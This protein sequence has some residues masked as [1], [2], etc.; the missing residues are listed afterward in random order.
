MGPWIFSKHQRLL[1]ERPSAK[2]H[3][4]KWPPTKTM[5]PR[6]WDDLKFRKL[7]ATFVGPM[8]PFL[9]LCLGSNKNRVYIFRTHICVFKKYVGICWGLE[10]TRNNYTSRLGRVSN[11]LVTEHARNPTKFP[12]H[13]FAVE[14]R[15]R[16]SFFVNWIPKAHFYGKPKRCAL[17]MTDMF[18]FCVGAAW[19]HLVKQMSAPDLTNS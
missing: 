1:V 19:C 12:F 9:W 17:E 14:T 4:E 11:C 2:I 7:N 8:G 5:C 13:L 3:F 18:L 15:I 6:T 10:S 16:S